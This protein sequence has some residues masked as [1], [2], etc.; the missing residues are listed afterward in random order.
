MEDLNLNFNPFPMFY[1]ER[2]KL[3]LFNDED[4]G[5]F[6][7]IRSDWDVMRSLDKHPNTIAET[8]VLFNSILEL[9]NRNKSIIWVICFKGLKNLIGYIGFHKIDSLHIKAE[10]GYALFFN[11]NRKGIMREC[12]LTII[13]Y[14]FNVIY[15]HSIEANINRT[16]I[17]SRYLLLKN[18]FIK[19]AHFKENYYFNGAFLD[20]VIYSLLNPNQKSQ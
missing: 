1:T 5:D 8:R 16:N 15:F 3:R 4:F 17:A 12:L 18:H 6:L 20:S 7:L 10:I 14:G 2:L 13:E 9:I 11:Q 19:E